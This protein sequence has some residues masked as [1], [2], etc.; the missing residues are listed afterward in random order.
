M[1]LDRGKLAKIDRRVFAEVDH[2]EGLQMVKIP[3]SDAAWSTWH[4]YCDV[5]GLTMGEGIAGLVDSEL[6]AVVEDEGVDGSCAVFA[7]RADEQLAAREARIVRRERDLRAVER[8][9]GDSES[10]ASVS[11]S[12]RLS[13][14]AGR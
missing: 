3:L 10:G 1:A 13:S 4:R 6:T 11:A 2:G 9:S 12:G 8:S 7:I 5:L 14:R